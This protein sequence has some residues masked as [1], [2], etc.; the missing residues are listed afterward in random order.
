MSHSVGKSY[1]WK[2]RI[3]LRFLYRM[4]PVTNAVVPSVTDKTH[5]YYHYSAVSLGKKKMADV[6]RNRQE[7][8]RLFELVELFVL[9]SSICFLKQ[10]IHARHLYMQI[11]C[12]C[13]RGCECTLFNYSMYAI[14]TRLVYGQSV[15]GDSDLLL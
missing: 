4:I 9:L 11:S 2:D 13:V 7:L 1:L 14:L 12:V 15:A 6:N 5:N 10:I 3:E 8:L